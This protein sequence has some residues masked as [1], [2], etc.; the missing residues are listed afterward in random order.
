MR[1]VGVTATEADALLE[2]KIAAYTAE[3]ERCARGFRSALEAQGIGTALQTAE[4][5]RVAQYEEILR[6]LRAVQEKGGDYAGWVMCESK[7]AVEV[8]READAPNWRRLAL[9]AVLEAL[10]ECAGLEG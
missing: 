5:E 2:S 6:H 3:L 7:E 8:M 10:I 1:K 9:A 4:A